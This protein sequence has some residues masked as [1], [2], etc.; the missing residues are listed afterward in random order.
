MTETMMLTIGIALMAGLSIAGFGYAFVVPALTNRSRASRRMKA[1]T[2]GGPVGVAK[3]GTGEKVKDRRKAISETLAELEEKQKQAKKR[4]S[5]RARMEQA[6]L[7]I[8][9]QTYY[10]ASVATGVLIALVAYISGVHIAITGAL[11]FAGTVG[12]PRWALGFMARRRQKHFL[13]EFPNAIDIIVRG[14]KAGLPLNEC[15]QIIANEVDGPV[16]EEFRDLVEAQR[17]GVPVDQSMQ[18]LHERVPLP[19]V[20]FLAIVIIIQTKSGG[21]LSEALGNLSKVL[22]A[23]RMLKEKIKAMSSEAKASASIIG[24]LPPLV[25]VFIFFTS[26][27]YIMLLFSERLGNALLIGAG[28]WMGTG[29][30]IMKKM[31]NFKS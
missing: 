17:L 23:R 29:I 14:V 22:R 13:R 5:L 25:M 10:A 7:E 3:K 30:F 11:A 8:P 2:K 20:N 9:A 16:G 24:S 31:I 21:N 19:E 27:D 26:P 15:L 4:L 12:L 1:V 6:G 18:R 28:L